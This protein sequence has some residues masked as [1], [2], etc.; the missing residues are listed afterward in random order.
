MKAIITCATCSAGALLAIVILIGFVA[1][2][3]KNGA[4]MKSQFNDTTILFSKRIDETLN[5]SVELLSMVVSL[6]SVVPRLDNRTMVEF[7]DSYLNHSHSTTSTIIWAEAIQNITLQESIMRAEGFTNYNVTASASGSKKDMLPLTYVYPYVF[8]FSLRGF[9]LFSDPM[10]QQSLIKANETRL[11]TATPAIS[12]ITNNTVLRISIYDPV[13]YMSKRCLKGVVY[14][15][16]F[17]DMFI[18]NSLQDI[19]NSTLEIKWKDL[20]DDASTLKMYHLNENAEEIGSLYFEKQI[21]FAGRKWLLELRNVIVITEQQ[22]ITTGV[23]IA[24]LLLES[25]CARSH[26]RSVNRSRRDTARW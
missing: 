22:K 5:K 26:Y 14:Q 16:F 9:D 4:T 1:D 2:S 7:L 11:I 20:T 21:N 12:G 25:C 3:L 6:A 19:N 13:F 8:N 23:V 10:R 17:V 18:I 15:N 24:A